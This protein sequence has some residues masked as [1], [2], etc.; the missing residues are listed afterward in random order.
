MKCKYQCV[1]SNTYTDVCVFACL[2]ICR[3]IGEGI[4]VHTYFYMTSIVPDN[5]RPVPGRKF[6]K[7]EAGYKTST[8]YR[9]AFELQKQMLK[10]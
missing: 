6:R 7:N 1:Y 5:A 3:R 8:A 10:S 2:Q 9:K 4:A